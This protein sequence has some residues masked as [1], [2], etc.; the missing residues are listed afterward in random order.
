MM[1]S[2]L[3]HEAKRK[4]SLNNELLNIARQEEV[5]HLY[6]RPPSTLLSHVMRALLFEGIHRRFKLGAA[7]PKEQSDK[8]IDNEIGAR[9]KLS[10]CGPFCHCQ[11][12]D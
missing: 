6:Y 1:E 8:E 4:L 2:K 12:P 3:F 7:F 5:E 11:S 9:L 10:L